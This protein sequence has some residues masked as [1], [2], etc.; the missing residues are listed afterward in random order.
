MDREA[1]YS[2]KITPVTVYIIISN[3]H[4]YLQQFLINYKQL[5]LKNFIMFLS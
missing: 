2:M 3:K 4:K 1:V 5:F